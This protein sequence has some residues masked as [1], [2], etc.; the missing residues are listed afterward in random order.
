MIN[1]GKLQYYGFLQCIVRVEFDS[2]ETVLFGREWY[3]TIVKRGKNGT[4][5]EDE[6]GFNRIKIG[7]FFPIHRATNEPFIFPKD[8][9]EVFY[10]KDVIN[11]GWE[12][13]IET[14]VL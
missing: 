7:H 14:P 8:V 1:R 12:I 11:P 4:L 3:D 6:C 2:F 13:A 10:M 9:I 5:V